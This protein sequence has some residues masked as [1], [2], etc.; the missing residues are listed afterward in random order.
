M[1]RF[2]FEDKYYLINEPDY[3][4]YDEGDI[5]EFYND[6]GD[7]YNTTKVYKDDR[8]IFIL[9]KDNDF[10]LL[11][12]KDY[13]LYIRKY[14]EV[15]GA[16]VNANFSIEVTNIKVDGYYFSFNYKIIANEKIIQDEYEDSHAWQ[17]DRKGFYNFLRNGL[18]IQNVLEKHSSDFNDICNLKQEKNVK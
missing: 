3:F 12:E 2:K 6:C 7:L 14:Y 1:K 4:E 16:T 10:S 8:G 5:I 15:G 11:K 17:N 9:K 13:T 18:A